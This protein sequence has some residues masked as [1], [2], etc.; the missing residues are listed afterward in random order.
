M[1]FDDYKSFFHLLYG[2]INGVLFATGDYTC[3]ALAYLMFIVF[4][5]Y[6]AFEQEKCI[7][8]VGDMIEYAIGV[9]LGIWIEETF[10]VIT[11][12]VKNINDFFS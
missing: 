11:V 1:I 5:L 7:N 10:H 8:K 9:G 2:I 4:L 6:Q 12:F 3:I